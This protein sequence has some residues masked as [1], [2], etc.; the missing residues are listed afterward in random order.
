M[1]ERNIYLPDEEKTSKEYSR[2]LS[3]QDEDDPVPSTSL[4]FANYGY[5]TYTYCALALYR[6]LKILN[7]GAIKLFLNMLMQKKSTQI[8]R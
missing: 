2:L 3:M 1:Q 8:V 7:P 6:Q 4:L 5:G